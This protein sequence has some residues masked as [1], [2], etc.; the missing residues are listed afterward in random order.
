MAIT[1]PSWALSDSV[2]KVLAF[3]AQFEESRAPI[4][5]PG[6]PDSRE[7]SRSQ[8]DEFIVQGLKSPHRAVRYEIIDEIHPERDKKHLTLLEKVAISDSDPSVRDSALVRLGYTDD[9]RATRVHR[10]MVA[11]KDDSVRRHALGLLALSNAAEDVQAIEEALK[12]DHLFIRSAI[13]AARA[14]RGMP[15]TDEQRK[16]AWECLRVD[17]AWMRNNP[18]N[19]GGFRWKYPSRDIFDEHFLDEIRGNAQRIFHNAGMPEDI[20]HLEEFALRADIERAE[21]GKKNPVYLKMPPGGNTYRQLADNLRL[22]HMPEGE[23]LA[24]VKNKLRSPS[25]ETKTWAVRQL[26]A[27]PGGFE[28]LDSLEIDTT[29]PAHNF[30]KGMKDWCVRNADR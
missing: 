6:L 1:T 30:S 20:P 9:K 22:R 21:K 3:Y 12:S 7:F 19:A 25:F 4:I 2:A 13:I 28:V 24:F 23:R 17:M 10:K 8:R 5:P 29:H 27:V 11:D 16:V 14:N 15:V 18:V 26:C